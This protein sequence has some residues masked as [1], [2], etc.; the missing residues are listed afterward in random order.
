MYKIG[1]SVRYILKGTLNRL[2]FIMNK[3]DMSFNGCINI[4]SLPLFSYFSFYIILIIDVTSAASYFFFFLNKDIQM[5]GVKEEFSFF[6]F[7]VSSTIEYYCD[8]R[9]LYVKIFYSNMLDLDNKEIKTKTNY[10]ISWAQN[11]WICLIF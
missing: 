3:V 8:V 6:F 2:K 5:K 4:T 10:N 1:K 7:F 9:Y 11:I